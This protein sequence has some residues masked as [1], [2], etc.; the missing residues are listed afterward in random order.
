M[1][2]MSN[3]RGMAESIRNGENLKTLHVP[4]MKSNKMLNLPS[5]D[6][7]PNPD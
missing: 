6:S 3:Q 5:L 2:I 7:D 1:S 4:I